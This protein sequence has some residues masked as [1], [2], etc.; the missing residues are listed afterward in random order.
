MTKPTGKFV[1]E[2]PKKGEVA[3]AVQVPEGTA[4]DPEVKLAL[5]NLVSALEAR[6]LAANLEMADCNGHVCGVN[7]A[8][9]GMLHEKPRV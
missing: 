3:V 1:V 4:L 6:G 5:T 8:A 2:P 7:W 9:K